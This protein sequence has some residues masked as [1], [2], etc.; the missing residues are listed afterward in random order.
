[1]TACDKPTS[2]NRLTRLEGCVWRDEPPQNQPER[3]TIS[4]KVLGISID[5]PDQALATGTLKE[6]KL[7][8]E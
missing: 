1:M 6:A 8:P 3:V 7:R 4:D 2:S 5:R